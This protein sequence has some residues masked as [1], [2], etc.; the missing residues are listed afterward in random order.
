MPNRR[1]LRKSKQNSENIR[2]KHNELV[3][4]SQTWLDMYRLAM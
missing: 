1:K 4:D 3:I 2:L